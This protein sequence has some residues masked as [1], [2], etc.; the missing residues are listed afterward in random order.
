MPWSGGNYTKGN[1]ATGGWSGDQSAG[2]G[3]EAGRHDT[4][5]NDF[6]TGINQCL[7]KDGSNTATANLNIGNFRITNTGAATART[8]AAQVAQVQDGDYIWLGTTAGTA[9][10][11]TASATPAITAYKAGQKFRA[12]IGV[13]LGSTGVAATG[14]TIN[15]NG[16]GA[17]QIVSNDGLNLSPTIGTWVAGAIIEWIYDGTYMRIA[18]DPGGW[19]A[20][21]PTV[22]ATGSMTVSGL[23]ISHAQY[24]KR[25]NVVHLQYAMN[26][27][28]GGTASAGIIIPFPVNCVY[29]GVGVVTSGLSYDTAW[30]VGQ[31]AFNS[32]NDLVHYQ[33]ITSTVN[34]ALG[35]GKYV[36]GYIT[37]KSA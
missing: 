23:S 28:L 5:D 33:E 37:Y 34:W 26:M 3:I 7:N 31:I 14:H 32:V 21:T 6:A 12:I 4:Q 2:I 24:R 25:G 30:R 8:D 19:L 36:S 15:I 16:I 1:S 18:N 20:Y 35:A 27:T 9:T 13:G 11:Q 29:S 22:T 17:K 10:A